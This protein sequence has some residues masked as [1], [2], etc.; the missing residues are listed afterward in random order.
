MPS[1]NQRQPAVASSRKSRMITAV[2]P[3]MTAGMI[4]TGIWPATRP[5]RDGVQLGDQEQGWA[6]PVARRPAHPAQ[7]GHQLRGDGLV[8]REVLPRFGQL[9][10][11]LADPARRHVEPLGHVAGAVAQSQRLGDPP[12]TAAEALEPGGE[13]DAEGDDLGHGGVACVLHDRLFPGVLLLVV[14]VQPLDDDALPPL[15]V[16]AQHRP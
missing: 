3:G 9:A 16:R 13:I 14:N 6:G 1:G 8:A 11:E 4:R 10:A 15:A 5:S 12:V 7:P 2:W